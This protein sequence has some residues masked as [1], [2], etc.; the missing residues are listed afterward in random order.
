VSDE[1]LTRQALEAGE[2][3]KAE[4]QAAKATSQDDA[5]REDRIA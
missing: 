5:Q 2:R 4:V 1:E 3:L